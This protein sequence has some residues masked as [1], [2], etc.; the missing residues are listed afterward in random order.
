[1]IPVLYLTLWVTGR[2]KPD[3]GEK[4]MYTYH[5]IMARNY[6]FSHANYFCMLEN[7]ESIKNLGVTITYHLRRTN[8][9]VIFMQKQTER[10]DSCN[11]T[12]LCPSPPNQGCQGNERK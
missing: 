4:N 10:L 7:V 6:Y 2:L 3:S 8:V 12:C 5:N 1:M 9:S 11:K